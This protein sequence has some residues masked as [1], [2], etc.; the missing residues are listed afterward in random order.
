MKTNIIK[1][2]RQKLSNKFLTYNDY[3]QLISRIENIR[4]MNDTARESLKNLID[5]ENKK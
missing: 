1:L 5:K 2:I 4:F 3:I